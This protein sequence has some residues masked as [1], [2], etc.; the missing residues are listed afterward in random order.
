[1]P[2]DTRR[3]Q[4]HIDREYNR[5]YRQIGEKVVW[6]PFDTEKSDYHDIYDEG[7]RTY[8]PGIHMPVLWIDQIEDPEQYSGEGRRP[9]QR[10]RFAVSARA[11]ALRGVSPY[12]A[13]GNDIGGERPTSPVPPQIGRPSAPWLDDRLNDVV[14]YDQ[15]FYAVSQFQIRGRLRTQDVI[16][17]VAAIELLVDDEAD[18]DFFFA[19]N[20]ILETQAEES[21]AEALDIWVA[22]GT[23]NI[24]TLDFDFELEGEWSA[25]ATNVDGN[26]EIP[27]TIDNDSVVLDISGFTSGFPWTWE[28]YQR[29]PSGQRITVYR[30]NIYEVVEVEDDDEIT[31]WLDIYIEDDELPST[32]VLE[33]RD[34]E[35]DQLMDD[36]EGE[37]DA[38]IEL[39]SGTWGIPLVD[40]GDGTIELDFSEFEAQLPASW[41]LVQTSPMG[42]SF[43]VYE[44]NVFLVEVE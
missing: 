26:T 38:Y 1:M 9:T 33:F 4:R 3:E 34:P 37:W 35:T 19:T 13:H 22:A 23:P 39:P 7:G 25:I 31:E 11:L 43:K 17:G 15:R 6:F 30:G 8:R 18:F 21:T 10:L 20:K 42:Q 29:T 41:W 14:F 40:G 12:E 44:G 28:L 2:I 5:F 27:L 36:L 24:V 32:F 16:I